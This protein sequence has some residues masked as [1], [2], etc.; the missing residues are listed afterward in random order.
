MK[1]LMF[2]LITIVLSMPAFATIYYVTDGDYFGTKTIS[3]NDELVMTGGG[4]LTLEGTDNS[5]L[6]ISNTSSPVIDGESGIVNLDMGESSGLYFS[7]G[8]VY[9]LSIGGSAT[10]ILTGGDI[11][12]IWGYYFLPAD[13]SHITI[14]CQNDWTYEGGYLSG[15]WLDGTSFNMKLVTASGF[16]DLFSN[17]TIIPEPVSIFLLGLGGLFLR[18]RRK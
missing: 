11:S 18:Q 16:S 13:D 12:E 6:Y 14:Y 10:A 17:M 9:Q 7:G 3:G 5:I 15:L 1:Q 8:C 2:S 4:G